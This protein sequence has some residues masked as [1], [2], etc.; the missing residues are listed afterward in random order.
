MI[1]RV[2]FLQEVIFNES[3]HITLIREQG[4][5]CYEL[6]SVMLYNKARHWSMALFARV[7]CLYAHCS[8]V[9][10]VII[11]LIIEITVSE[12]VTTDHEGS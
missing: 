11:D 4:L 12:L 8:I 6:G 2:T 9:D 3:A 10:V 5:S 7:L 1:G